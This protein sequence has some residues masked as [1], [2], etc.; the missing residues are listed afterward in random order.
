MGT[1]GYV[2][3]NTY[4]NQ[5]EKKYSIAE[6]FHKTNFFDEGMI[7]SL[8]ANLFLKALIVNDVYQGIG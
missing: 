3:V 8:L 2:P 5:K 6:Q 4:K 1:T 7:A